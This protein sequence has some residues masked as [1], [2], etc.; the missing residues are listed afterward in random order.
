M[1]E[2]SNVQDFL[3]KFATDNK[4]NASSFHR[5]SAL[6]RSRV[7][8][9]CYA[10]A[11]D[12]PGGWLYGNGETLALALANVRTQVREAR[13]QEYRGWTVGFE[14][15]YYTAT[16]PNY[17]ASTD[18][19]EGEWVDN[20]ECIGHGEC[21]TFEELKAAIDVKFEEEAER[22]EKWLNKPEV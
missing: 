19:P 2:L 7:F 5:H 8:Y 1:T 20:G 11:E 22:A 6:D 9:G 13:A 15:G 18:G 16:G 12:L 4:L 3:D 21:R 17:D 10:H 14:Y